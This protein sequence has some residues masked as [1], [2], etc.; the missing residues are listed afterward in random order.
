MHLCAFSITSSIPG[1]KFN[2]MSWG[3]SAYNGNLNGTNAIIC[4][5]VATI[6]IEF[7][8]LNDWLLYLLNHIQNCLVF[9][10]PYIMIW[11]RHGLEG[12]LFGILKKRIGSP[13]P[14]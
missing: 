9:V 2:V 1:L 3:N 7:A 13:Y 5:V 11:Y 6:L 8:I 12:A 4:Q 14:V 10:Q